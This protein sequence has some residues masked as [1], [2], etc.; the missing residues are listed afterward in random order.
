VRIVVLLKGQFGST[1][2]SLQQGEVR[3]PEPAEPASVRHLND[4]N[5][6]SSCCSSSNSRS[7][8]TMKPLGCQP[9][10]SSRQCLNSVVGLSKGTKTVRGLAP[11]AG[12]Q[13]RGVTDVHITRTG[14]P[15]VSVQGGR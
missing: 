4:L 15:I 11:L 12:V 14:K 3:M 10:S 8:L 13:R 1:G 6:N 9:L 2:F 5:Y 7:K